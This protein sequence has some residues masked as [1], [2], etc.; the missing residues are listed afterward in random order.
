MSSYENIENAGNNED[1]AVRKGGIESMS[2]A[3]KNIKSEEN[4]LFLR[5]LYLNS[6]PR[7]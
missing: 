7:K 3:C 4:W 5:G 6:W 1:E 2:M